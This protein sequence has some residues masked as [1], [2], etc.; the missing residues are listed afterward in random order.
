MPGAFP[1]QTP[2]KWGTQL[3]AILSTTPAAVACGGI[4]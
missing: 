4:K 2:V 3:C 1:L